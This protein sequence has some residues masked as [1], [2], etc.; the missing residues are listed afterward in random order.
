[1][2]V[3]QWLCILWLRSAVSPPT[4]QCS[5]VRCTDG[6]TVSCELY[7]DRLSCP[8]L[9]LTAFLSTDQLYLSQLLSCI[10]LQN[11]QDLVC[12]IGL[13]SPPVTTI[14]DVC[15]CWLL[16][17]VILCLSW[18]HH[19]LRK[20][21]YLT[22]RLIV[23]GLVRGVW[24][25]EPSSH[26]SDM[27]FVTVN[28]DSLY[29]V[30][31]FTSDAISCIDLISRWSY[32][33]QTVSKWA[34]FIRSIYKQSWVCHLVLVLTSSFLTGFVPI[35]VL[36]CT[37]HHHWLVRWWWWWYT[38]RTWSLIG[39]VMKG[40]CDDIRSGLALAI[41]YLSSSALS[42]RFLTRTEE[43]WNCKTGADRGGG[44]ADGVGVG[45][46]AHVHHWSN[47]HHPPACSHN[48]T[49]D[50][51][52]VTKDG[53]TSLYLR[54]DDICMIHGWVESLMRGAKGNCFN[55]L[56]ASQNAILSK[57]PVTFQWSKFSWWLHSKR[58]LRHMFY[59][60]DVFQPHAIPHNTQTIP[61]QYSR[62]A[63]VEG[64]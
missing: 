31:S 40:A 5:L 52:A 48:L 27:W 35:V 38:L 41:T 19:R 42:S 49:P 54:P 36:F 20:K 9:L 50:D 8:V 53:I 47:H 46:V 51:T 37:H 3:V 2:Y 14:S 30:I 23:I 25:G 26:I 64:S 17:S 58:M 13:P 24:V 59:H 43:L 45:K 16:W 39:A 4:T 61:K 32:Q 29:F 10:C 21:E 57:C 22:V 11:K 6:R 33:Q 55:L 44:R 62:T 34:N 12:D 28:C 60:G 7:A 15:F 63:Q 18:C 1:M 56:M